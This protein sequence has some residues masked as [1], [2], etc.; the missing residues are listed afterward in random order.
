M[1]EHTENRVRLSPFMRNEYSADFLDEIGPGLLAKNAA[2]CRNILDNQA[3]FPRANFEHVATH[4]IELQ[5]LLVP[6]AFK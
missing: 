5:L 3:Q 2:A 1:S 4:L 6:E